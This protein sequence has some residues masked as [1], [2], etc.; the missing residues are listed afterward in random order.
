MDQDYESDFYD[1]C[2]RLD[3][4]HQLINLAVAILENNLADD[5]DVVFA[6]MSKSDAVLNEYYQAKLTVEQY[7]KLNKGKK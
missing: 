6:F 5:E 3:K 4:A 7:I 2:C 1:V